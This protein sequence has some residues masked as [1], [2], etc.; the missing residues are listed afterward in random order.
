MIG[1]VTIAAI[2]TTAIWT[3]SALRRVAVFSEYPD[4]PAAGSGTN[5][6]PVGSDSRRI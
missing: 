6:L 4:R 5:W 2:L 3:E 1:L